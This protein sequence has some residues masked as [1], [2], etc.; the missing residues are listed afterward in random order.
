MKTMTLNFEPIKKRLIET[1][2]ENKNLSDVHKNILITLTEYDPIFKDSLGIKGIYIK[3]ENT[4]WLHT[5][6]NKT[7]VNIEI[8]Y[9]SGNDLYVVRFHK[10]KDNFDVETR[11]FTHIFFNELYDLLREQISK[12]VYGA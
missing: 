5:K 2:R 4:L 1:I 6:N 3:D 9:D 7:V 11:E 12:L 10:L 8:S